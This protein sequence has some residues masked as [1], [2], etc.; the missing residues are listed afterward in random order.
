ML[1]LEKGEPE[2]L[3]GTLNPLTAGVA[4]IGFFTQLLP[5]PVPPFKH[6]KAIM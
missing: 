1:S 2:P 3:L 5:H 4:Y 6:V